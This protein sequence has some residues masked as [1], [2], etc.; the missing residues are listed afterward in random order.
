MS[1]HLRVFRNIK[2]DVVTKNK[3]RKK[4]DKEM[5]SLS[6][7]LIVCILSPPKSYKKSFCL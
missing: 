2:N 1:C 4:K 5:A 6:F 3:D 7:L